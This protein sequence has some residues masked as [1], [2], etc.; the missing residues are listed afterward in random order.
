MKTITPL[1]PARNSEHPKSSE[2]TIVAADGF[3]IV[4]PADD[5]VARSYAYV[6]MRPVIAFRVFHDGRRPEPIT[7]CGTDWLRVNGRWGICGPA[8]NVTDD[9][10][11]QWMSARSFLDAARREQLRR[12]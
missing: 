2:F 1:K 4:T 12:A 9:L 8:G 6:H 10:G 7:A 3:A 11:E 5:H